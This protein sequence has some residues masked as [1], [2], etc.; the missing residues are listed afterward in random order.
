M[1]NGWMFLVVLA[2][3]WACGGHEEGGGD[4]G[5][6]PP[7][8]VV[9]VDSADRSLLDLSGEDAPEPWPYELAPVVFA[10]VSDIHI[11]GS[12]EDSIAQ[13][14][15]GLLATAAAADPSPEFIAIT[16]D[17]TDQMAEPVDTSPGSIMDALGKV[18][19]SSPVPV[20]PVLG[21]HDY[22]AVG[23]AV[24][25]TTAHP[26]E[27]TALFTEAIGLEPWHY[28]VHGGMKFVHLNS[29]V[30]PLS[31]KSM[32]LNGSMGSEQLAW[33]DKTLSDGVPALLFL[34]HPPSIVLEEG[35][36]TLETLIAKHQD[37][38]I[39][40]F[41]GHIHVFAKAE[42][43]GVPVYITSSGFG[44]QD[45]HHVRV[46]PLAGTVE[47]LNQAGIDYGETDHTP[48]DPQRK[49]GLGDPQ[50]LA[51]AQLVLRIP[52]GH[53][54]PMGLGTYLRELV[55]QIPMALQLGP[56]SD[57]ASALPA[58]ITVAKAVG[59]GTDDLPPHLVP[60]PAGTCAALEVQLEGPC[61]TTT[62]VVLPINLGKVLGFPL[63]MGW[64]LRAELK[65]LVMSGALLDGALVERGV[66]T[67]T[68][69]FT[70]GSLDLQSII[71][72]EY[73][74]GK[75][76]ACTPGEG[77][78]PVCPDA[79]GP[80]FF[81]ALPVH[82]DVSLLGIGLRTIFDIF[83]SVP[84]LAVELDANFAVHPATSSLDKVPGTVAPD[85]FE[86]CSQDGR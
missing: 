66:L 58:V 74:A 77:S 72:T 48:C 69:D 22:Y 5:R 64:Q 84:D 4:G 67:A 45:F 36:V 3:V 75:M 27:R 9:D 73:C 47:I 49:P 51:G 81:S 43:S 42:S 18:L 7:D 12:F 80:E 21:N 46:D 34:H 50:S 55:G 35:D 23:D 70:L 39:A 6:I 28:S 1:K 32:G 59:D 38:L 30:G 83:E 61:F 13:K 82:C 41:V 33:L 11:D 2:L 24:F 37:T 40:V 25:A 78:L 76:S 16:G 54:T 29:L 53:I 60:V 10:V 85:L 20:E 65:N 71:V 26:E 52:D 57:G 63:P 62:P 56:S 15:V 17:L 44:G 68:L 8:L 14:V 19:A 79:P 31:A 86:Q